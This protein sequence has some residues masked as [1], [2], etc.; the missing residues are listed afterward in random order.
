MVKVESKIHEFSKENK[1]DIIGSYNPKNLGCLSNEFIDA[2]H[3]SNLCL[4]KLESSHFNY[5]D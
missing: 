1:I 4:S 5:S 2:A 3:P